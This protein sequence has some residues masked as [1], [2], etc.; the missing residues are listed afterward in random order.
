MHIS[1]KQNVYIIQSQHITYHILQCV[2]V[3][4][5]YSAISIYDHIKPKLQ[6]SWK[7]SQ[8]LLAQYL[9]VSLHRKKT[10]WTGDWQQVAMPLHDFLH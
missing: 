4:I 10:C 6:Q 8:Y 9:A 2:N 7:I 3:K 5:A 1:D